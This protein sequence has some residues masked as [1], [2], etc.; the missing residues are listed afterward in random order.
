MKPTFIALLALCLCV[1]GCGK[2]EPVQPTATNTE[3]TKPEKETGKEATQPTK[4][5]PPKAKAT[6]GDK[7]W[8]FAGSNSAASPAIGSDGTVYVG[9]GFNDNCLVA[10]NGKSGVKLWEFKTGGKVR[11]SP[12]IGSD[13]TVYVGSNDKKLYAINGKSGVKLW[14]FETGRSVTSSPA[15]GSDGTIYVGSHDK[16]LYAIKADSKGLA[17]SPWPMRGQNPRH[18]G[19]AVGVA[20]AKPEPNTPAGGLDETLIGKRI[21]LDL[22]KG[23]DIWMEFH[24]DGNVYTGEDDDYHGKPA[25]WSVEGNKVKILTGNDDDYM[26][27]KD[28][29]LAVGSTIIG[30]N[31]PNKTENEGEKTKIK[32]VKTRNPSELAEVAPTIQLIQGFINAMA[33]RDYEAFKKLTCLGMTKEQFKAFMAQNDDRKVTRAWDVSKDDFVPGLNT[34][35]QEAFRK[36]QEKRF[37]WSRAKIVDFDISDDVKAE[38]IS[39]EEKLHLLFDDCFLTPQGKLMFNVPGVR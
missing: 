33:A 13:G 37:D 9:G 38:L 19:R 35:I 25:K 30:L 27:F 22:K 36:A 23:D 2:K 16:K 39:G 26:V 10:I 8:G 4:P 17:K 3:A 6:A 34:I 20:P 21:Y 15:I 18:T 31:G 29:S 1:A 14:E 7:L 32:D 28:T 12:A 5:E 24:P 11:S